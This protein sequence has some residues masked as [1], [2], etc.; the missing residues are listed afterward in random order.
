M[1]KILQ[2]INDTPCT[3][4]SDMA[5]KLMGGLIVGALMN[6][7]FPA[8]L[9]TK[10]GLVS[11]ETDDVSYTMHEDFLIDLF[12]KNEFRNMILSSG[13]SP[14][15][16][17][18]SDEHEK[19]T[20]SAKNEENASPSYSLS[21]LN[22]TI[23]SA[24]DDD[25]EEYEEEQDGEYEEYDDEGYDDEEYEEDLEGDDYAE[26]GLPSASEMEDFKKSIGFIEFGDDTSS[27]ETNE[28]SD[29]K[30]KQNEKEKEPVKQEEGT[31]VLKKKDE[32]KEKAPEITS[33]KEENAE[34]I[35]P[36][37]EIGGRFREKTTSTVYQYQDE[38][39]DAYASV[40]KDDFCFLYDT[41]KIVYGKKEYVGD[42]IIAPLHMYEG[43]TDVVIWADTDAGRR[44]Y[45]VRK[46]ENRNTVLVYI[47]E[48]S[49][50]VGGKI[51][52]GQFEPNVS[53]TTKEKEAGYRLT[54]NRSLINGSLGHVLIGENGCAIHIIPLSF[55]N[56]PY[57]DAEYVYCIDRNGEYETGDN[58]SENSPVYDY[59]GEECHIVA[60]WQKDTGKLLAASLPK[61]E[62]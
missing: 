59:N 25:E 51:V 37:R 5:H 56:N 42:I 9:D 50:I 16:V 48:A 41:V 60:K 53:L 19:Q 35:K 61:G 2:K 21:E 62:L 1:L 15:D 52:N 54:E 30:E 57:G 11:I 23:G 3:E 14:K 12:G 55:Q 4:E 31:S 36:R 24:D 43:C 46:G 6:D 7:G 8:I 49:L 20:S 13:V 39:F 26:S 22:Q 18:R 47:G 27:D 44:T 28:L 40:H 45:T 17:I 10:R 33:P 38:E 29:S 32:P 34:S 58:L